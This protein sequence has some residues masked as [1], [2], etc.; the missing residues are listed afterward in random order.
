MGSSLYND[1]MYSICLT[2]RFKQFALH[3]SYWTFWFKSKYSSPGMCICLVGNLF[4][5]TTWLILIIVHIDSELENRYS[6]TWKIKLA[7][8]SNH[9][10]ILLCIFLNFKI[11]YFWT[12]FYFEGIYCRPIEYITWCFQKTLHRSIQ[13]INLH[14][15]I[16]I[17]NFAL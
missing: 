12:I 1:W 15:S 17:I 10:I 2:I 14:R 9:F 6:W 5:K 7:S 13:I 16:Q 4:Y 8:L 3:C 11:S